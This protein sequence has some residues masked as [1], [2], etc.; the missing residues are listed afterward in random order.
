[1]ISMCKSSRTLSGGDK[2]NLFEKFREMPLYRAIEYFAPI[3][4]IFHNWNVDDT[5]PKVR[6]SKNKYIKEQL[7]RA[8]E[9]GRIPGKIVEILALDA[10]GN[11]IGDDWDP[12][13]VVD[14]KKTTIATKETIEC[15]FELLTKNKS[16]IQKHII[17]KME[18][19]EHQENSNIHNYINATVAALIYCIAQENEITI[20]KEDLANEMRAQ[21]FRNIDVDEIFKAIPGYLR[22]QDKGGPPKK[23]ID[24]AIEAAFYAGTQF[25]E[26]PDIKL[27]ELHKMLKK[28]Q[29]KI[30]DD[31]INKI[32][33]CVQ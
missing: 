19:L 10:H 25:K 12:K 33:K 3:F 30:R 24:K 13:Y 18:D 28:H 17:T 5:T 15:L 22:H 32:Y 8:V 27:D 20:T 23:L 6:S 11:V 2:L 9:E 7:I 4:V 26:N 16:D 21:Q 29:E 14:E 31:I 1:M